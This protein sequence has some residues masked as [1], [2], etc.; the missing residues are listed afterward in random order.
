M[1][2]SPA[3][4]NGL[5]IEDVGQRIKVDIAYA[6][7]CTAGKKEDMECTA[8]ARRGAGRGERVAPWVR[9]FIHAARRM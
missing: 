1:I 7:S 9:F 3:T 4:R 6:G 5:H 2:A 8:R